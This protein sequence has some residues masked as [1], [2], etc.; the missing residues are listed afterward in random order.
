MSKLKYYH[1]VQI[2]IS[3]EDKECKV[4]ER[5]TSKEIERLFTKATSIT[6]PDDI[7]IQPNGQ[8]DEPS[9]ISWSKHWIQVHLREWNNLSLKEQHLQEQVTYLDPRH[10]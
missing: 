5:F 9:S 10:Q 6:S 3:K 8:I 4:V 1:W 2:G 7:K